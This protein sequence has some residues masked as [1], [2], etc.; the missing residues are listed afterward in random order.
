MGDRNPSR[1]FLD[2][3]DAARALVLCAEKLDVSDPVNIGTGKETSIRGRGDH[4]EGCRVRGRDGLGP[5]P[6]P[7]GQPKRYR[8]VSRARELV[9][10]EPETPLV[11]GLKRP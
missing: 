11:E 9:G 2:V 8:D 7:D 5:S 10:F 4:L 6:C 1:E 3:D